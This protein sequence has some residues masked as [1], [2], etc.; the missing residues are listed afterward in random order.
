MLQLDLSFLYVIGSSGKV[1]NTKEEGGSLFYWVGTLIG[2]WLIKYFIFSILV[3]CFATLELTYPE[4]DLVRS[5]PEI[6]VLDF[7]M[8]SGY[9]PIE[10]TSKKIHYVFV[11][12]MRDA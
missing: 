9:L 10:N 3:N 12:S 8:Y 5:L 1:T 11:E 4:E 7:K 6:G 2:F